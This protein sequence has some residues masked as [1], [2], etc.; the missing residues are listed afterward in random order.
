MPPTGAKMGVSMEGHDMKDG[1]KVRAM[2]EY[3]AHETSGVA[4][5]VARLCGLAD[6][7]RRAARGP[8]G[9]PNRSNEA[10]QALERASADIR[11][12]L[13]C[14]ENPPLGSGGDRPG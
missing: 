12:A 7:Y 5:A 11:F 4:R 1:G 13:N 8:A 6:D 2:R 3:L 10:L 9:E 14:Y